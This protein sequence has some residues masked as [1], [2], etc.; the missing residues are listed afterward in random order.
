VRQAVALAGPLGA[1][2]AWLVGCHSPVG[3]WASRW[4]R[5]LSLEPASAGR[6]E[7][8]PGWSGPASSP[9]A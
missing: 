8:P 3:H 4:C 7:Q 2:P 1:P 5:T 9:P 6:T